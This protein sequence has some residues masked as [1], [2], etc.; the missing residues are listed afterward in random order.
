M[1]RLILILFSIFVLNSCHGGI[2]YYIK[3]KQ[4]DIRQTFTD[5]YIITEV[6][7]GTNGFGYP[8]WKQTKIEQ[9]PII[10]DTIYINDIS[11]ID[12]IIVSISIPIKK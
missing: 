11:K 2:N 10:K 3:V 9:I 12:S 7:D 6:C 5:E 1:K 4:G 8:F